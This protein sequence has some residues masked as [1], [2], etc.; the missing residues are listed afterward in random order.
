MRKWMIG[1]ILT[2]GLMIPTALPAHDLDEAHASRGECE[3]ALARINT[4]DRKRVSEITG[5][6]EGELNRFFHQTFEC[7]KI[8]DFWYIVFVD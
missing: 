2:A 1:A 4:E 5:E 8:G 7:E 3:A 6:T